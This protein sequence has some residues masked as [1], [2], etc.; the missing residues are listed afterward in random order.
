MRRARLML[1]PLSL[2]SACLGES[3]M[4]SSL[5]GAGISAGGSEDIAYAREMIE[6]GLIPNEEM[7]TSEGLFS[8]HDL[9][10]SG[11][12]CADV[13]CPRGA[14]A[15]IDPVDGSGQQLLFQLG[16]GTKYEDDPF[17]RQPLRLAAT[18]DVSGSMEG[19]K[20]E[21][22]KTALRL[23]V[24]QLDAGD[25]MALIAF[26]SDAQVERSMTVM[27]EDGR[28][29]MMR[30]IDGL[31]IN[32]STSVEAGLTAA[33]AQVAPGAGASGVED[34]VM[35][36]TDAQPNMGATGVDS[37]VGMT[38]Y[39]GEAGIGVTMIGVGY[40]MGTE[41]ADAISKTRGGNYHFLADEDDANTVFVDEFAFLV[42]PVAYDLRVHLSPAGGLSF[43][44]GYGVPL[45]GADVELGASTLFLSARDGGMGATLV[46][47]AGESL[48]ESGEIATLEMDYLPVDGEPVNASL[49]A[50]WEGGTA[51]TS[52][53]VAADDLGVFKMGVLVDGY[54]A[55]L[56]GSRYCAG[57][58]YQ[59][60]ALGQITEASAR[61]AE[62]A[63][64]LDD[65]ELSELS[66][67]TTALGDN[68]TVG[69]DRCM[70]ADTYA[71]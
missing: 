58:L 19:D 17:E 65:A 54:L 59:E 69:G 35:V 37:F 18:V 67:L 60:E 71:Y 53:S 11:E 26:G 24:E 6:K 32:G 9:P 55:L 44:E 25:E 13:L 2:L 52:S 4:V 61:I 23:L 10:V 36:F 46:A 47:P 14:A 39:Y 3:N 51:Y 40:D 63:T 15:L 34:R 66:A 49:S 29:K 27:D 57:E 21:L 28:E 33:Y 50:S 1:L 42:S 38:A 20:I 5:Q 45:D 16:F 68:V 56:A 31:D 30:A 12:D 41:L 43:L 70:A 22:V 62:V 64:A 48:P 7:F 8:E